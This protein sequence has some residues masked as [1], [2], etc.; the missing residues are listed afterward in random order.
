[1]KEKLVW[2]G[3]IPEEYRQRFEDEGFLYIK[4]FYSRENE[5]NEIKKDIYNLIGL[6]IRGHNLSVTQ[7][8]FSFDCFDS[9]L[10]EIVKNQRHLAAII[11]N[12]VKKLPSYIRLAHCDRHTLL[13]ENLLDTDFVGFANRG[14]GIRM[15]HPNEDSH[16]TQWHQDYVSQLCS[17]SGIVLWSPLRDV[18]MEVGPVC[19]CPGSHKE[20]IFKIL[21]T[22][23]GSYGLNLSDEETVVNRY[24]QVQ[25]EVS[26]GDVLVLDFKTL[27][28]SSPNRSSRTRWAMISRLFNFLDPIGISNGWVGG[29]QEGTSFEEI[30]PTL[31]TNRN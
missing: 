29:L 16:L 23:P 9:G 8:P 24:S 1:M 21:K 25:P 13:A 28:C 6:T 17:P 18:T 2:R 30:H 5:I 11:Y 12:A 19:F 14:Y 26:V 20:G 15:D 3:E 7:A 10:N 27:H 22:G 4:D 31:I